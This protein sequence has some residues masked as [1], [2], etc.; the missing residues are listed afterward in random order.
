LKNGFNID[1]IADDVKHISHKISQLVV[2]LNDE[3][4]SLAD[5]CVNNIESIATHAY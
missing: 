3:P 5:H 2:A 1:I 4:T